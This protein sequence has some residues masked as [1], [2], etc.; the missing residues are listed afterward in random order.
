MN[1]LRR[2]V[3]AGAVHARR[4]FEVESR[5]L[6]SAR[7]GGACHAAAHAH[8]PDFVSLG[9]APDVLVLLLENDFRELLGLAV[10]FSTKDDCFGC[11]HGHRDAVVADDVLVTSLD[12]ESCAEERPDAVGVSD[13]T[14]PGA[15]K[16]LRCGFQRRG[17]KLSDD[18][19]RRLEHDRQVPRSQ[20]MTTREGLLNAPNF[21]GCFNEPQNGPPEWVHDKGCIRGIQ[22]LRFTHQRACPT[23]SS[24]IDSCDSF[25]IMGRVCPRSRLQPNYVR[26]SR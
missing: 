9:V 19:R 22:P 6:A 4:E 25:A 15:P 14:D 7:G 16:R 1:E 23:K 11:R 20:E 24:G 2:R 3:E 18:F 26:R 21:V 12:V 17:K 8:Q 5:R 10:E 13:L